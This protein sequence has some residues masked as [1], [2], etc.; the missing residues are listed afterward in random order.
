[1]RLIALITRPGDACSEF[2]SG[3]RSI[4]HETRLR[5]LKRWKRNSLRKGRLDVP[6]AS[7]IGNCGTDLTF[8]L[9]TVS[10]Y[11]KQFMII[12][13]KNPMSIEVIGRT[14]CAHCG[15]RLSRCQEGFR[16]WAAEP[17][18][19]FP[20]GNRMNRLLWRLPRRGSLVN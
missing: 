19:R 3:I 11:N 18:W 5:G 8:W 2:D 6:R 15:G 4:L 14:S 13:P 12:S 1:M 16:F 17:S 7:V 9:D 10:A 20:T